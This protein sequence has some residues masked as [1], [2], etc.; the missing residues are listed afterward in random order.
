MTI[1]R[2]SSEQ[3][4]ILQPSDMIGESHMKP[5]ETICGGCLCGNIRYSIDG[6]IGEANY[7]HCRDCRRANGSAFNVGVRVEKST[8]RCEGRT[9]SEYATFGESGGKITRHF[10]KVC[11]SPVFTSSS[12]NDDVIHVKAGSLD[13]PNVVAPGFQIWTVSEVSW[14]KIAPDIPSFSKNR[15]GRKE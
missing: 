6:D 8:F 14:A 12:S 7:C 5:V 1:T 10:C 2:R 3:G 13:D 9:L 11:G 4:A 15:S